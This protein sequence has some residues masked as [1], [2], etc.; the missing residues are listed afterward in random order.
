MGQERLQGAN[1]AHEPAV[2][3]AVPSGPHDE[4]A[5]VLLHLVKAIL[6]QATGSFGFVPPRTRKPLLRCGSI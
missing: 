2:T 5:V 4:R 6:P 1:R 3:A